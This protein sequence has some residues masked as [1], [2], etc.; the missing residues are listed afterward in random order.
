MEDPLHLQPLLNSV[1]SF[2]NIDYLR[3]LSKSSQSIKETKKRIQQTNPNSFFTYVSM[4]NRIAQRN[5]DNEENIQS[6]SISQ[7]PDLPTEST[8]NPSSPETIQNSIPNE[9]STNP[10]ETESI[11]PNPD[12]SS[13]TSETSNQTD[14]RIM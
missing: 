12:L 6:E 1:R 10:I 5:P 4:P 9:E 7:N 8:S 2:F 13:E 3:E 14:L 11:S